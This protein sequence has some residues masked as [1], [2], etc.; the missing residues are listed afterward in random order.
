VPHRVQKVTP[1]RSGCP[2][3]G[4]GQTW[5][6]AGAAGASRGRRPRRRSAVGRTGDSSNGPAPAGSAGACRMR[7]RRRASG[8]RRWPGRRGSVG[9]PELWRQAQEPG[10]GAAA[11]VTA[12]RPVPAQQWSMH[13]TH[14][15]RLAHPGR[16]PRTSRRAFGL[17]ATTSRRTSILRP[18]R[19]S[20]GTLGGPPWAPVRSHSEVVLDDRGLE[21]EMVALDICENV[22]REDH[23]PAR[24]AP[25][26]HRLGLQP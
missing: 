17:A 9:H 18:R 2:Q 26:C 3:A 19:V 16:S 12:E 14:D 25:Q 10:R 15:T 20:P 4:L 24:L 21:L 13:R 23:S 8:R 6:Q 5:G 1:S 7:R 11:A 22:A